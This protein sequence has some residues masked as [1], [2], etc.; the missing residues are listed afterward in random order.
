MQVE[1]TIP[2]HVR[3]SFSTNAFVRISA[4]EAIDKIAALGYEGVE[5]L[6]DAPHLYADGVSL[7]TLR[8]VEAV[9]AR[10]N[11]SVAN[12]NANTA[13]GYYRRAFWEPLFEPSLAAPDPEERKWRVEYTKKCIDLALNFGCRNVSITSGRMV[14]GVM[15]EEGIV[16]FR[17]SLEEVLNYASARNVNIGI[18]YEP[19]LLVEGFGEVAQLIAD[20][21][22]SCLG[23]NLDLGHS[24]VAGED[25]SQVLRA[26]LGHVFHLHIEDIRDRK[27][28]HRVPGTGDIDFGSVFSEL[29]RCGYNGFATVELYTCI[30]FPE[31][32]A[33][34]S[35]A[36]LEAVMAENRPEG[37]T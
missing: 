35:L 17:R 26:L 2:G 6:A 5:I 37:I 20:F 18:E 36:F 3:L 13:S 16:L 34:Q 31:E 29:R 8:A 9:L 33:R 21:D 24:Y 12:V 22:S 10:T 7:E 30:D 19:G 23:V 14:P 15:P 1:S 25:F 4:A 27:H 28:Y 32:A 11:I